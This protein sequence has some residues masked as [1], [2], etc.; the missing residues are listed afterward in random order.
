MKDNSHQE[1][2]L[3][4]SCLRIQGFLKS[5]TARISTTGLSIRAF[6]KDIMNKL[7]RIYRMGGRHL[8]LKWTKP[9]NF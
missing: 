6:T 7:K 1:H 2:F 4:E 9:H 3:C 5:S 8:E